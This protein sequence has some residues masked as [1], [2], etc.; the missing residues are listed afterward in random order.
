MWKG[1]RML[2]KWSG[3]QSGGEHAQFRCRSCE[4]VK[5][6]AGVKANWR[7]RVHFTEIL[8]LPQPPPDGCLS[9]M[10]AWC[11]WTF[12]TSQGSWKS[13]SQES[14]S[15]KSV[16]SFGL[17]LSHRWGHCFKIFL[18]KL[19]M[20]GGGGG[21]VAGPTRAGKETGFK[22][23]PWCCLCACSVAQ[24]C[25]T[26]CNPTGCSP[27][28]SSVHGIL[29][30]RIREWVPCPPPGNLPDPGIEARS[31]V[32]RTGR[33]VSLPLTAYS[34]HF[35]KCGPQSL[36]SADW[37]LLHQVS[38]PLFLPQQSLPTAAFLALRCQGRS[39]GEGGLF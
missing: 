34:G 14:V 19:S 7:A 8:T 3:A 6:A 16:I 18:Q 15:Q 36:S 10:R 27:P 9:G 5:Q 38:P 23:G 1:F 31:H 29:Q 35:L 24:S 21:G 4:W 28:G 2:L 37:P 32:S 17:S 33:Q 11:R 30:A 39:Q 26:L 22:W 12:W 13:V 20:G 25:L